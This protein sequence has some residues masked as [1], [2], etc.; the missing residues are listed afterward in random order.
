MKKIL[1]IVGSL[2]R[3]SF[4]LR[5]AKQ[6][7]KVLTG[8]AR[9]EWLNY[10]AVPFF[11]QDHEFPAPREIKKVRKAVEDSDGIWIFTPEY[12]YQIPG[13]LKN[14]LDWLSR[15][16]DNHDE[17]SKSVLNGK[18]ATISGAAGQSAAGNVLNKLGQ[19]M[20]TMNTKYMSEPLTGVSIPKESFASDEVNI[21]A[22]DRAKLYKQAEEF[23][24]FC[25]NN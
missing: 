6:A 8:K 5:L 23:L 13:S 10:S 21:S 11:N 3:N 17:N 22:E 15:P 16:V 7:E 19:L 24:N 20:V 1:F 12:N 14:L 9:V 4:N 25:N 2:R 18:C